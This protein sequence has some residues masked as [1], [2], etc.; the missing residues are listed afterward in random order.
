MAAASSK[1]KMYRAFACDTKKTLYP[2][3][4]HFSRFNNYGIG[5][6]DPMEH[7]LLRNVLF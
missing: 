3:K 4:G 6:V 2:H 7:R 5:L 1:W